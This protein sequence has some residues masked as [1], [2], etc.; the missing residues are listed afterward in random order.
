MAA[1]AVTT[2]TSTSPVG[3]KPPASSLT[4]TSTRIGLTLP[5]GTPANPASSSIHR[6]RGPSVHFSVSSSP[7]HGPQSSTPGSP[8]PPAGW[9]SPG[10]HATSPLPP[11]ALLP[12]RSTQ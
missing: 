12:Q 5:H 1:P 6:S 7:G 8:S 2:S 4:A 10:S 3:S 9:P 11:L